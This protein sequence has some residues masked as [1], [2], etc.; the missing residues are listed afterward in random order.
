MEQ[1]VGVGDTDDG[2]VGGAAGDFLFDQAVG[3]GFGEV[4]V[5]REKI[6]P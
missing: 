1:R 2:L 4:S 3:F 5:Q 6:T